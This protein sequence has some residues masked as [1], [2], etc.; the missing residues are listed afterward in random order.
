MRAMLTERDAQLDEWKAI[1]NK[2]MKSKATFEK[3]KKEMEVL[4]VRSS[5][6]N[7]QQ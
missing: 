6:D 1:A 5:V 7:S 4:S 2:L 3:W